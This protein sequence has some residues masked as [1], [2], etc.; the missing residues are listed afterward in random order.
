MALTVGMKATTGLLIGFLLFLLIGGVGQIA[1]GP[2]DI[3]IAVS[4]VVFVPLTAILVFF[5]WKEKWWAYAGTT[6]LG[7]FIAVV[8]VPIGFPEPAPALL[9]WEDMLAT[10]FGVLMALEGFKTYSE[11]RRPKV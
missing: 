11:M 3:Y 5:A 10:V 8:S 2:W 9:L 6:I 4:L 1:L 7:G